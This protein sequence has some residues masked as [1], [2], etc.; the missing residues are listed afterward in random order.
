MPQCCV[1]NIRSKDIEGVTCIE[2]RENNA[3]ISQIHQV[4]INN[5]CEADREAK[6]KLIEKYQK[7]VKAKQPI[8]EDAK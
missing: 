1:C 2:C 3:I 7:L 6:E 4:D 5:Q 8:F